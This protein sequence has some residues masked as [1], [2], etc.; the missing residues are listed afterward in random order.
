MIKIGFKTLIFF[1]LFVSCN[2]YQSVHNIEKKNYSIIDFQ[3]SG[4]KKINRYLEKNFRKYKNI[5]NSIHN[6]A[7][8]AKSETKKTTRAKNLSGTS[9]SYT[10]NIRVKLVIKKNDKILREKIFSE[11]IDYNNLN[12]KFELNQYE[13]I[14]IKNQMQKIIREINYYIASI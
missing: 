4:D 6:Y 11:N 3:L 12:N 13:K 5:P 8:E 1:F 14:I 2:G 7:I 10:L 9:E